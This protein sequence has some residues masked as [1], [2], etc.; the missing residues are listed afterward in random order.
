MI[1]LHLHTDASADAQHS[2]AELFAMAEKCGL[3]G[4]A[5]ADHNTIAS[6]PAGRRLREATGIDFI[7][8]VEL[9]TELDGRELHL[10]GYGFDERAP[11]V[12]GWFTEIATLF[13]AQAKQR[14]TRFNELGLELTLESVLHHSGCRLPTGSS[15]FDALVAVPANR[16]HPL[17]A[18]Y[19]LVRENEN[20]YI[21]F[22]F[23]VMAAGGPAA[24]GEASLPVRSAVARFREVKAVPVL[25]HPRDLPDEAFAELVEAGLLGV[26]AICSYHS[27]GQRRHWLAAARHRGLL[28]TAGS[29]FHGRATKPE[30]RLGELTGNEDRLLADLRE[31]Q[32]KL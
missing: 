31:V 20:H 1:D 23:E 13:Q 10:L 15:F 29:D 3:A 32:S 22:Y 9:T 12:Q 5:F 24:V 28:Y 14:V 19:L 16:R 11:A 4:L 25:A 6:L 21:R 8:A 17:L 26:E 30:V 7:S 27:P 18:P 2:P